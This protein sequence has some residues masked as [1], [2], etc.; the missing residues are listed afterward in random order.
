MSDKKLSIYE[1]LAKARVE[2]Q[3]SKLK[4]SGMNA[5]A[6]FKYYELDDF[7]PK[8]NQICNDLG[9]IGVFNKEK[10]IAY[11]TFHDFESDQT[12]CFQTDVVEAAMKG[13]VAIQSLGATHTYL[14]RYL[15]LN[16]FEIAENDVIDS[17]DQQKVQTPKNNTNVAKSAEKLTNRAMLMSNIATNNLD[18]KKIAQKYKI[19]KD[20]TEETYATVIADI[21]ANGHAG[22][23][24]D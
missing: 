14:K 17:V 3:N 12:I 11:L 10:E 1:K 23:E 2:L 6:K 4:K 19:G 18:V 24:N 8:I 7:L 15:Y 13:A 9:L 21:L 22:L 20:T 16:A 5:Y